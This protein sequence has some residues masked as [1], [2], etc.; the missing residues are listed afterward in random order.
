MLAWRRCPLYV[1]TRDHR[2]CG[3]CG[4]SRT[5][6]PESTDLRE[7][8]GPHAILRGTAGGGGIP[9]LLLGSTRDDAG[10][11]IMLGTGQQHWSTVHAADLVD[12]FRRVLKDDAARGRYVIGNGVKP[13]VAELTEAA[14]VAAVP[15]PRPGPAWVLLHSGEF[16]GS[17]ELCWEFN[18]GP[19]AGD[20][21]VIAPDRLGFGG[22][23]KLRDFVSGSDRMIRSAACDAQASDLERLGAGLRLDGPGAILAE[24]GRGGVAVL[25]ELQV[26]HLPVDDLHQDRE[27]GAHHLAQRV[28]PVPEVAEHRHVL[29]G[30]EH[31]GHVERLGL[32]PGEDLAEIVEERLRA[33]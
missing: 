30:G 23:D 18:I 13:T 14:A 1:R 17:A 32:P 15:A 19:L 5:P 4:Q 11:L 6:S 20:V 33:A 28:R 2:G 21:R 10:H 9:G 8:V 7:C 3:S 16:G 22:T 31:R 27:R 29:A 24:A 26:R 12:F 25:E